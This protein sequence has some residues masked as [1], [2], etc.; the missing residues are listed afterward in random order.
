MRRAA[1]DATFTPVAAPDASVRQH[2]DYVAHYLLVTMG[3]SFG[4]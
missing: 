4:F 1:F 2:V 3:G